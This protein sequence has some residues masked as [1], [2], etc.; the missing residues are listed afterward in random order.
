MR[1]WQKRVLVHCPADCVQ[2]RAVWQYWYFPQKLLTHKDHIKSKASL[3]PRL[4]SKEL[5]AS[6]AYKWPFINLSTLVCMPWLQ[7][8]SHYC[9]KSTLL[10]MYNFINTTLD[11]SENDW[12]KMANTAFHH[13]T[14][15]F[16]WNMVVVLCFAACGLS[17][18]LAIIDENINS[19]WYQQTR[20]H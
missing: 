3:T 15:P 5:E 13:R 20:K 9:P 17:S 18:Y 1:I 6:V 11:K 8:E 12:K 10:S 7:G 4:M 16:L 2:I 19:K 14:L